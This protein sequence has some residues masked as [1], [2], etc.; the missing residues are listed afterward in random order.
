MFFCSCSF[1]LNLSRMMMIKT[2]KMVKRN[3]AIRPTMEL[4]VM[5]MAVVEEVA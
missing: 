1:L 3:K 5:S 4:A 2:K